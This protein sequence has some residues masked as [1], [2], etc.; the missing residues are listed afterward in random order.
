MIGIGWIYPGGRRYR[1][2]H[3]AIN[4]VETFGLKKVPALTIDCL[5][6][7]VVC[8]GSDRVF[9][10]HIKFTTQCPAPLAS[11]NSIYTESIVAMKVFVDH[12]YLI[13]TLKDCLLKVF[14][15]SFT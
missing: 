5:I 1:A 3:D 2:P 4:R 14:L 11:F 15:L 12:S 10:I 13:S 7:G 8:L 9:I 6:A